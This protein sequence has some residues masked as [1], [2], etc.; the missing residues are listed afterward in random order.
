VRGAVRVSA[1]LAK[2]PNPIGVHALTWV[3]GWSEE[4]CTFAARESASLG[5]DLVE[6]PLLEPAT[7][8]AAMTKRIFDEYD[9]GA[10]TSLGLSFDADIS[11][12]DAECAARGEALLLEALAASAGMG[13]THM[14][15]ILYSALGKYG[16][17]PSAEGRSN[18]V[19]ALRRVARRA[20]DEGVT[21]GLE[22]V[23]RYESNLLNTA[24]QAVELLKEIDEA[25][26][27]IHLDAYHMHIE[28]AGLAQAVATAG[29]H[30][31]YVHIG[32]SNR[33]DLGTGNVDFPQLFRALADSNYKGPITFESFSSKVVSPVLSNTLCIWRDTWEDSKECAAHAKQFID[34]QWNAAHL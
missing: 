8:N 9:I 27:K 23:N 17:P 30:L 12:S 34:T 7:V 26:V 21:L 14:C 13:A 15:G 18:C 11:S 32:E 28:E 3:G 24:A 6:I 5:Y 31:G 33:G 19:A 1:Q 16:A 10:A 29:E 22:V 25:N 20:A 2:Q 4:E